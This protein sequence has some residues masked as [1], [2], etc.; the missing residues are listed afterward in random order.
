MEGSTACATTAELNELRKV[1]R[2]QA[3]LEAEKAFLLDDLRRNNSNVSRAAEQTGMQKP[4]FQAPL[5]KNEPRIH[6]QLSRD[7]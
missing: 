2:D 3:E 6:D 7:E 1:L 5:K 4:N